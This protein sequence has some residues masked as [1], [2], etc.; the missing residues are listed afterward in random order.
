MKGLRLFCVILLYLKD[1]EFIDNRVLGYNKIEM[2]LKIVLGWRSLIVG[3]VNIVCVCLNMIVLE[4]GR[5][6]FLRV[7]FFLSILSYFLCC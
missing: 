3:I 7:V 6:S 5:I 4:I 2:C 1:V